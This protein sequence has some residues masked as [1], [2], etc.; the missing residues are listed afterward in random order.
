LR[1]KPATE[2][3]TAFFFSLFFIFTRQHRSIEANQT[4]SFGKKKRKKARRDKTTTTKRRCT[5][6]PSHAQVKNFD[7]H[8]HPFVEEKRTAFVPSL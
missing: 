2:G 5:P 6:A 1:R 4:T 7:S 3:R 8:F